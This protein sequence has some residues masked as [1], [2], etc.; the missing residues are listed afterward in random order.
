MISQNEYKL[1]R[2][3]LFDL[4]D[5][6]SMTILFS[7]KGKK[8]SGDESSY[9]VNKNF[10]YLT[11]IEQE[12]SILM[13]VKTNGEKMTYL[14]IDEKDEKVEKWTGY[15]LSIEEA[16]KFSGV[17]SICLRST[18]DGKMLTF[19]DGSNTFG[20]I[21][22]FYLDLETELKIND[23]QTT[24]DY[25]KELTKE[26]KI[27]VEDAHSFIMSLRK[28]KSP[29]EVEEIREAIRTTGLGLSRVL[30]ELK[31]G[32]FEYQLRNIF[33]KTVADDNNS[34]LAF[35]SI[36]A[37]G[38]NGI[39]LHYPLAKDEL[40]NG[41]LVLLDVGAARNYYC[42][43]ISR[44]YPINGKYSELQKKIYNIVL[45]C[46]KETINFARPGITLKEMNEFAKN[47]LAD[48]CVES[49]L[50][51]SKEEISNVY[52]HSVSHHLGLD[53][54]DGDDRVSA[55]VP[56]NVITCE[57]GLYFKDLGIGIRIED[58][59]LITNEGSEVLSSN[60]V[61]EIEQIEKALGLK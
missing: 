5:D 16:K 44:T 28:V 19:F 31:E 10:Y 59:I 61:K 47:F 53:T 25:K 54:H 48:E 56:G 35:P 29:A 4:L 60:I 43:D 26:H 20:K 6:N 32:L 9:V 17:E 51:N 49:G 45:A 55:L 23:N 7:G 42:G 12:N 24:L 30:L 11:G 39:I 18:F 50:I 52:Y 13:L 27:N 46:N 34:K 22:K 40:H 38:K 58:D 37:S 41:D 8:V 33:E 57:P 3:K 21:E 2:E 1:R 15:K 14:F 36:V